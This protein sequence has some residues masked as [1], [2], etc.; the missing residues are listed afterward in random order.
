M[1]D[2]ESSAQVIAGE[3]VLFEYLSDVS[4][5]PKYFAR[6]TRAE[7]VGEEEIATEAVVNG[8]TESGTAWLRVDYDRKHLDWGSEGPSNYSGQL[9]VTGDTRQSTVTVRVHT[10]RVGDG[11]PQVQQGLEQTLAQIKQLVEA[12]PG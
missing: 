3:Q 4:N 1:G 8:R 6:M 9:D 7:H 10:E 12:N 11:D 5:L 2:Y